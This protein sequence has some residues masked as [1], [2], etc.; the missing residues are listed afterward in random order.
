MPPLPAGTGVVQTINASQI[1]SV[2]MSSTLSSYVYIDRRLGSS[3]STNV[4]GYA[5]L[6]FVQF[7]PVTLCPGQ[8]IV[9]G[10]CGL[11]GASCSGDT[12]LGLF[13]SNSVDSRLLGVALVSNDDGAVAD[14]GQCSLLSSYTRRNDPNAPFG[15]K[16]FYL[17]VT[18]GG[19]TGY[20]PDTLTAYYP[21]PCAAVIAYSI[22]GNPYC[23]APP[24]PPWPVR[25]GCA[26][27]FYSTDL[28]TQDGVFSQFVCLPCP[29]SSQS[30]GGGVTLCNASYVDVVTS[31][32]AVVNAA[33]RL[34]GMTLDQFDDP[35]V[36]EAFRTTLA[37]TLGVNP[38]NVILADDLS[39]TPNAM[40]ATRHLLQSAAGAVKLSCSVE[41]AS[42]EEAVRISYGLATSTNTTSFLDNLR[43][44]NAA[45]QSATSVQLL[46]EPATVYASAGRRS[47]AL[48]HTAIISLLAFLAMYAV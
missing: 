37:D 21:A 13:A 27:N 48:H 23:S 2:L 11:E 3:S 1:S 15:P 33:F 34:A 45:F 30:A 35:E 6:K 41:A 47:C 12:V 43:A 38:K 9:A 44:V 42:G 29:G 22:S 18:C 25:A 20:A 16:T 32:A 5:A 14:C 36:A 19:I 7:F 8:T 4:S 31:P 26:V 46:A 10:T 39:G 24:P 28:L 17:G 40:S